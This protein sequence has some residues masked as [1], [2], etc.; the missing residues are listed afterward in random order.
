[1]YII[2]IFSKKHFLSNAVRNVLDRTSI[3][4]RFGFESHVNLDVFLNA[5]CDIVIIKLN[6]TY[7]S[8]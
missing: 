6:K 3:P 7:K 5:V 2:S 1:M 8:W 4:E